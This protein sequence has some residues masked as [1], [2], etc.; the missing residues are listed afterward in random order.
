MHEVYAKNGSKVELSPY[1]S[2]VPAPYFNA[3]ACRPAWGS[4]AAC[5]RPLSGSM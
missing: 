5:M 3:A 2:Y 4:P 1:T